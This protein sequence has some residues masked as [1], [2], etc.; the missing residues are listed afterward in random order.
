MHGG[1]WEWCDSRY[2]EAFVTEEAHKGRELW[3]M[4]GGAYYSPARRCRS[5]QRNY[6]DVDAFDRPIGF[7]IVMEPQE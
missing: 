6:E 2:P 3:V 4:R 1:L 7:R 5:S